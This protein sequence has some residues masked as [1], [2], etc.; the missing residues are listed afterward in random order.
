MSR[1]QVCNARRSSSMRTWSSLFLL[2]S[3]SS[4]D[5]ANLCAWKASRGV[6]AVPVLHASRRINRHRLHPWYAE[7]QVWVVFELFLW[8]M[9]RA[10]YYVWTWPSSLRLPPMLLCEQR[11][12]CYGQHMSL[13]GKRRS[14]ALDRWW[15]QAGPWTWWRH[16][17]I[18]EKVEDSWRRKFILLRMTTY[19]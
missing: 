6:W 15:S 9:H 18:C 14:P 10:V 2:R 13:R 16:D 17:E 5:E 11:A 19:C 12:Y 4:K 3:L 1:V 7:E 8:G